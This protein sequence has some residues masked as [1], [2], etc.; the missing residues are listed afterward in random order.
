MVRRCNGTLGTTYLDS[1]G[2]LQYHYEPVI[3]QGITNTGLHYNELANDPSA[4]L[5]I[6]AQHNQYTKNYYI[7]QR[8][9][10]GYDRVYRITNIDKFYSNDTFNAGNVGLITLYLAID[11]IGE[12]D[13]FV[14]RVAYNQADDINQVE[15]SRVDNYYI[16][17][18]VPKEGS[19]TDN[20]LSE[21]LPIVLVTGDNVFSAHLYNGDEQVEATI[22]LDFSIVDL[23]DSQW[24]KFVETE[25]SG[26][27][28]FK[29][30]KKRYCAHA[31]KL[32]FYT[33]ETGQLVE[34]VLT[35]SLDGI[36]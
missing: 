30:T 7:N 17:I 32:R 6:I 19:Q 3:Q 23:E 18:E 29:V 12:R 20:D 4:A 5:T 15:E 2:V 26:D 28:V 9:I 24:S 33:E 10:I 22:H 1:N 31:L 13:D 8:F 14:H 16:K 35:V 11:N 21:V 36:L 25:E 34:T 27:N